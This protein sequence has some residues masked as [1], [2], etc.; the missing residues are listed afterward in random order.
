MEESDEE[1]SEA[2][3][4]FTIATKRII[5]EAVDL[6]PKA[7]LQEERRSGILPIPTLDRESAKGSSSTQTTQ[8]LPAKPETK[9]S[10]WKAAYDA[11]GLER[12]RRSQPGRSKPQPRGKR[13]IKR[14][15]KAGT[16]S[17]APDPDNSPAPEP[18]EGGNGGD[19]EM[20]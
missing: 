13:V 4:L 8:P 1:S 12:V 11:V 15:S 3:D 16:S 9:M 7:E 20:E 18:P 14:K 5:F 10:I 2:L 6:I 19:I 17:S